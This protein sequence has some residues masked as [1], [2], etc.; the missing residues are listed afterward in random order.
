V[1]KNK[2]CRAEEHTVPCSASI[3]SMQVPTTRPIVR[4]FFVVAEAAVAKDRAGALI[5]VVVAMPR[6]VHLTMNDTSCPPDT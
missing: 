4:T 2:Q 1:Q 5:A 3:R 6:H